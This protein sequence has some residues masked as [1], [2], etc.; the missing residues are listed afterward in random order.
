M[1]NVNDYAFI[2]RPTDKVEFGMLSPGDTFIVPALNDIQDVFIK[3]A[4][5]TAFNLGENEEYFFRP[6][7]EV[8]IA[9]FT[10]VV[11]NL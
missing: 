10:L 9:Y 2:R 7:K 11:T 3:T 5:N 8:F 6:D 1:I 4:V